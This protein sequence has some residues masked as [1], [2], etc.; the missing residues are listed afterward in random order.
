MWLIYQWERLLLN[1][2]G[3]CLSFAGSQKIDAHTRLT[4]AVPEIYGVC[5][6][7]RKTEAEDLLDWLEANGYTHLGISSMTEQKFSVCWSY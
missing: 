6:D 1:F 3:Q 4:Q 5:A 7:L 2:A